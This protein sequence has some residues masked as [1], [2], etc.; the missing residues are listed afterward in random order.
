LITGLDTV[1]DMLLSEGMYNILS[2]HEK[3]AKA[4]R[5]AIKALNLDI[6]AKYPSNALTAVSV[7]KDIDGALMVKK[8]RDEKGVT[9]AGGQAELKGKIFRIAHMGYMD[10]YD[11]ICAITSL[12]M[13]L[14]Q[15]G[16]K[17]ELGK[18]VSSAQ[19]LLMD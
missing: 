6:F 13:V 8:M 4:T 9:I 11:C 18:G 15:L 17:I 14:T 10:E 16:A 12:E 3:L 1:L 2:R 5:A 7:P 19:K